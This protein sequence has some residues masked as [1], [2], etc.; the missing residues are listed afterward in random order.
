MW[1]FGRKCPH[2]VGEAK[3]PRKPEN[4]TPPF[5]DRERKIM[6]L[7]QAVK[8]LRAQ[9]HAINYRERADGSIVVTR[10]DGVSYRNK[11]GNAKVRSLAGITMTEAQTQQ[12]ARIRTPKG[13]FGHKKTKKLSVGVKKE[14]KRVQA[15]F[16][17]KGVEAGKP[18]T[19]NVRW[20]IEHLGEEEATRRLKQASRYARHI[21]YPEN[22]RTLAERLRIDASKRKEDYARRLRDVADY[23][24]AHAEDDTITE[25][26]LSAVYD[27][28]GDLYMA[29]NGNGNWANAIRN[30]ETIFRR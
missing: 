10:V 28:D 16:R 21:A 12:L 7:R 4:P 23:V 11:S 22:V 30:L 9:G 26:M 27:D 24:E 17:K 29:E 20:A 2:R 8:M 15:L 3:H 1:D 14:L 18:T 6:K 13:K 25:E 19:K 5:I